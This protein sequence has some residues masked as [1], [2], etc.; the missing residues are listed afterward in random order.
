M[1]IVRLAL[2][3][4]YTF[5]VMS[6][7]ILLLGI[8]A[9]KTM[10]IDIFPYIDIPVVSVVWSYNGIS[11]DEMEKR[12]VT[13]FERGMTTTVNDIEH[14]ESQSYTGV[15]VIRVYLQPHARV[16]LAMA[17]IAAMSQSAVRAMPPGTFPPSIL[18]YDAS[19][20][21]VLQLGLESKTVSEQQLFDL[22]QNYIRTPL[23]TVQGASVPLP[24]GGKMR[25]IVVDLDPDALYGKQLS[26]IDVSN[27]LNLQNLILPAGD[28]KIGDREYQVR[29]N[30]S[31]ELLSEMNNL[32]VKTVNGATVY[33]KDVANVRDGFAVQTNIVR[34]NGTRGALLTI[35][36]NGQASTLDIVNQVK[37]ILPKILAGLPPEVKVRQLFDQS[38]FVRASING[39]LKEA[40]GAAILTGLMI[41]LF[42]GS[43]R[44]TLIVCISIP[45]SIL[46]S[47]V[48]LDLF[49]ETINV[50]TLGGLALAVGIL[51]DDAT[52]EIE[53]THRNLA[54]KKPLVRA[55]LDGAM[56][57]AV[58]ALVSTLSICIVFVPVLLLTGAA[59]YL[60][61]PLAMGVVFAMLASYMLSR[62]LI[63]TMVHYLLKQEVDMYRR[64][65][66]GERE[67]AGK[68]HSIIWRVHFA[69]NRRFERFRAAYTGLLDWTLDHRAAVL[70]GFMAFSLASL[71]LVF[72]IGSDFFPTVDSGQIR[73]HARAG[74][75]TR[76]EKTE[77][78]FADIENE[79]RKVIP[80]KELETI[81]D[82]IGLPNGGFNLGFGDSPSIGTS[83][84]D[85][86]ISLTPEHTSTAVYT[87]RLRKRL[88]Q[89]F[90]D[91]VFFFEAANITNQI[92]N[93][94]LPAPIDVQVTGRDAGPNYKIAL[95]L[96]ERIAQI[97]GAAD[98]H[99]HQVVDG[100]ELRVNVDRVKAGQLGLTQHDVASSMLISLSGSGQV[101]PNQWLNWGNGVNYQV[102]VQTPQYKIDSVDALMRTP[103]AAESNTVVSNT[104]GST[105]GSS[106]VTDSSTGAA[107]SQSS[108]AY[109]NPGAL[110]YQ[111]Q[112]LSNL[113]T[114]DHGFTT[115]IVNHYNVQPVFDVYANVDRRDLGGV[116]SQVEKIM[117]QTRVPKTTTLMLRGE[118]KTMR[119]SFYRLGLGLIAAVLL[120]YLLM[121]VNFQSWVDPLIILSALPGALSGI[122][123]M[124]FVTQTTFS[125]PSLMGAIMCIGVA[126]ANSILMVVFA[127]DERLEGK[128]V[129]AAALSAGFTRL[130]P[131]LMTAA[132]MILGM[133]PMALGLGEGAEQNSPLGRA[134]IGGLL[135]A[136]VTTLFVVP[137]VYTYL[138]K[139][140]PV[141]HDKRIAEEE[142]E[143]IA[144][145]ELQLY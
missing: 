45:L 122:L 26:A 71:G 47:I 37:A 19:S 121:A 125:V 77:M 86:L 97:P 64:G 119:D 108:M 115:E 140:P 99:I 132:A 51:V 110:P 134:V 87:E 52:V 27:S 100:P 91:L 33:L 81:L 90:P 53:N 133:I 6:V 17:Q 16:D 54:M 96:A 44:S 103:I 143:V 18:K 21:P 1:W 88:H 120:V 56:Q 109:G 141:D 39:V 107:P 105:A 130:R 15:A 83:D 128:G 118:A 3:R 35:M 80:A 66:H 41:L 49:G 72:L 131:V 62:T 59:K 28:V 111:T 89:R 106:N 95:Q 68:P 7:A 69:F 42:L 38:L 84:G 127:N 137:I 74:A 67:S 79:I 46:T 13:P 126:T 142:R 136:T 63:P 20:V 9:I 101:A 25:Q 65:E 129:R 93:F 48:I 104:L 34:T 5:V 61:T 58:P 10:P 98:V 124:L 82:N 43:W 31:P 117:Q 138:R 14:I 76:I 30:S 29:L 32:P 85:I 11:S 57:I 2:R 145:L 78:I 144:E 4:P 75:G 50:M 112:L 73:L 102:L 55:V 113:A 23:A 22:G 8:T 135:L 114:I 36:R 94:G 92:V 123:W 139:Q 60:F 24:Y 116:T 12:I 40:A 70:A